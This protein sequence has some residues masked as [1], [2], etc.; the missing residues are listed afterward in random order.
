MQATQ[1]STT[2]NAARYSPSTDN[3]RNLLIIRSIAL[4]GQ[5]GVL[6]WVALSGAPGTRLWEVV[7]GL[8]LLAVITAASLWRTTQ[9]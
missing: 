3:L 9:N 5:A 1:I 6:A 7:L 8:A 2:P 4:V